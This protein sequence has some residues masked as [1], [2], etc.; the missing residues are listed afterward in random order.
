MNALK[1]SISMRYDYKQVPTKVSKVVADGIDRLKALN[2]QPR[3][4][5]EVYLDAQKLAK[6]RARPYHP[7][8]FMAA[9]NQSTNETMRMMVLSQKAISIGMAEI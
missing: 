2:F 4:I 8:R 7:M 1:I 9:C 3:N 6:K 5:L